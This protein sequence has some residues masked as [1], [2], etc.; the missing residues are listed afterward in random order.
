LARSASLSAFPVPPLAGPMVAT[1]RPDSLIPS[2]QVPAKSAARVRLVDS[3]PIRAS[4]L[5]DPY[6]PNHCILGQAEIPSEP[7]LTFVSR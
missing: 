5:L 7:A 6:S 2:A 1:G 3:P 4:E